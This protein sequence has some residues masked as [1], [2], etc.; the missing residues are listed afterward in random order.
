[1]NDFADKGIKGWRSGKPF[2]LYIPEP[3]VAETRL[4]LLRAFTAQ[5]VVVCLELPIDKPTDG[6]RAALL[7]QLLC[8]QEGHRLTSQSRCIKLDPS[9][10]DPAKVED[11]DP[12][13]RLGEAGG[14]NRVYDSDRF[15]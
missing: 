12:G 14:M 8:V 5:G 2:H 10:E 11:I 7:V 6:L 13:L 3:F 4:P 9:G 1:M 15:K